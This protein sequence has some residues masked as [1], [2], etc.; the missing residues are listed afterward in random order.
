MTMDNK[1]VLVTG[2]T[3]GVGRLVAL[4]LADQGARVLIH[5]RDRQRGD[6]VVEQIRNSGHSAVFLPADFSSLSEVRRQ[7]AAVR[8]EN[9]RLDILI[10]NAGIGSGGSH[11]LAVDS[12]DADQFVLLEHR[13]EKNG[14]RTRLLDNANRPRLAFDV[15]LICL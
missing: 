6:Q 9:D 1:T 11:L 14:A 12:G 5:G 8:Q 15:G 13:Y 2:S 4:R 10:N 7:A 3:D